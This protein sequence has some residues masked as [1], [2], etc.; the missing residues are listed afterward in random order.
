MAME[1][2]VERPAAIDVHQ[3]QLRVCVRVPGA[4]GKRVEEFATFGT[5]TPDLLTLADWLAAHGV[6]QVAMEG[7][8]LGWAQAG[9]G[10]QPDG[11]DVGKT[12]PPDAPKS[13]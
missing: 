3:A 6:T 1:L 13:A 9:S 2:V 11:R 5:T 8:A 12:P 4:K 7:G 10:P